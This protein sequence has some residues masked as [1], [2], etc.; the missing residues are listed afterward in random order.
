M[1][2]SK[3]NVYEELVQTMSLSQT[4]GSNLVGAEET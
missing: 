2:K 3:M 4:N 1:L